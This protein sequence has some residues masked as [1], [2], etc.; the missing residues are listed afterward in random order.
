MLIQGWVDLS[1]TEWHKRLDWSTSMGRSN[2]FSSLF[3]FMV[4][5]RLTQLYWVFFFTLIPAQW[6][7]SN[8]FIREY[9]LLNIPT[10]L[11]EDGMKHL[12]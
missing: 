7:C 12:F 9:N 10:Y 8:T 2:P 5:S 1:L 11:A 6:H 3:D 4:C